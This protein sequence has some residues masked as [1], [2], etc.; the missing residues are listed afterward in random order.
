[1]SADEVTR[2]AEADHRP[3]AARER[4]LAAAETTNATP[5]RSG[6]RFDLTGRERDVLELLAEGRSNPEIAE[7]LY[8]GRGTVRTHVSAILGKLGAKT[9]TEAAR[10]AM[11]WGLV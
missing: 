4:L 2:R 8:I 5:G 3:S 7:A 6:E 1:M 10:V 11:V 9:R